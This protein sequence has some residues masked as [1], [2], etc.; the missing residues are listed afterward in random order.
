[1]KCPYILMTSG[2]FPNPPD[3][4]T[5]PL[6]TDQLG[7][8]AGSAAEKSK[9]GPGAFRLNPACS[10]VSPHCCPHLECVSQHQEEND[11]TLSYHSF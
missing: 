11:K 10:S 9:A 3:T 6:V 5:C 2:S 4:H 1:M 8:M 7:D